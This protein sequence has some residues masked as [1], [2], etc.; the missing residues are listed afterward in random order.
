MG[1]KEDQED[2]EHSSNWQQCHNGSV[3]NLDG[4]PRPTARLGIPLPLVTSLSLD[5][6]LNFLVPH[7]ESADDDDSYVIGF[8]QI[9]RVLILVEY[10]AWCPLHCQYYL[11][12]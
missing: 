12:A 5:K 3:H 2:Q 10:L 6:S 9:L 8:L 7:L 11:C 1:I 4:R